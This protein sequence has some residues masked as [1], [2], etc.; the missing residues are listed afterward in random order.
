MALLAE[1]MR[2]FPDLERGICRAYYRKISPLEFLT[3][4][5]AFEKCVRFENFINE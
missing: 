5:T 1:H 4:L 3:L 2:A